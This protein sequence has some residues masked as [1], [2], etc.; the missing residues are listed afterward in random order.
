MDGTPAAVRNSNRAHAP[1]HNHGISD[2]HDRNAVA[3]R[4][5]AGRG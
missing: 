4:G 2:D 1:R 5:N 3:A